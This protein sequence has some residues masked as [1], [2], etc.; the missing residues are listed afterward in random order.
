MAG[1]SYHARVGATT[2]GYGASI[3]ALASFD[4]GW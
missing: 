1:E 4:A 3:S 2:G